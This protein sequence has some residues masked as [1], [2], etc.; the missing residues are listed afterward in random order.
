MD[1]WALVG[2]KLTAEKHLAEDA[3]KVCMRVCVWRA[4]EKDAL[5]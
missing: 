1:H 2:Q 3:K 5:M 4:R